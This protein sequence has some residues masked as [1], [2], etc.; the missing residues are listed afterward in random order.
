[1]VGRILRPS[2]GRI[3][4]PYFKY[5]AELNSDFQPD[6]AVRVSR[7][8]PSPTPRR[9][10]AQDSAASAPVLSFSVVSMASGI[11]C[12]LRLESTPPPI[13]HYLPSPFHLR[14]IQTPSVNLYRNRLS[15]F[16]RDDWRCAPCKFAQSVGQER[17]RLTTTCT[18][19]GQEC[20]P[21]PDHLAL[22]A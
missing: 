16:Q 5:F 4:C 22:E 8:L 18:L 9:L 20:P 3:A 2:A 7:H 15:R 17:L 21:N 1:M 14:S 10:Y 6:F 19:S 11:W 13:H 12:V